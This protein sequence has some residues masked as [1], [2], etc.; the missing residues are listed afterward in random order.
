MWRGS[1]FYNRKWHSGKW[2]DVRLLLRSLIKSRG[3]WL[4]YGQKHLVLK[5]L[6]TS[7]SNASEAAPPVS[8]KSPHKH[9]CWVVPSIKQEPLPH[10]LRV[11]NFSHSSKISCCFSERWWSLAQVYSNFIGEVR[12][13]DRQWRR[14]ECRPFQHRYLDTAASSPSLGVWCRKASQFGWVAVLARALWQQSESVICG[15]DYI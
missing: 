3:C 11:C 14:G 8:A 2:R 1:D 4:Y 7:K 13:K 9:L 12:G 15:R 5:A 6:F 10:W